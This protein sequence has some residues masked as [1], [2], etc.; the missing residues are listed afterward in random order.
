MGLL[1]AVAHFGGGK[2]SVF[3]LNRRTIY[4]I[5]FESDFNLI[6]SGSS[7]RALYLSTS[8]PRP[9]VGWWDQDLDLA[10]SLVHR[11]RASSWRR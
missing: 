9:Q 11:H 4:S 1:R 6:F 8:H 10:L 3:A 2:L 7:F 5:Q